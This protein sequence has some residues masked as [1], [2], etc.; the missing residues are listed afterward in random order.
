MRSCLLGW[1]F[2]CKFALFYFSFVIYVEQ[3]YGTSFVRTIFTLWYLYMKSNEYW[4]KSYYSNLISWG[5]EN[6]LQLYVG[7]YKSLSKKIHLHIFTKK[8][9]KYSNQSVY[10]KNLNI[11]NRRRWNMDTAAGVE[12]HWFGQYDL[13]CYIMLL[14]K[15]IWL[16][17]LKNQ[18][19]SRS[20][21]LEDNLEY[22]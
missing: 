16:V 15:K 9:Y 4:N 17:F 20:V 21:I 8:K 3:K 22:Y 18:L 1:Y 5:Q 10:N 7:F 13:T 11:V 2:F 14:A 6:K 12:W 19:K